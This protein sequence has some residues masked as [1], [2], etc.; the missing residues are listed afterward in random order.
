MNLMQLKN[1]KAAIL[2]GGAMLMVIAAASWKI[3]GASVQE[4]EAVGPP[5]CQFPT[6]AADHLHVRA[7]LDNAVRYIA[8]ESRTTD[9][10][11]G[12]P[13]EGWNDEPEKQLSLRSFTQLTAIGEWIEILANVIAGHVETPDLDREQAL[14]HLNLAIGTLRCDQ[15]DPALAA[16]GLLVNFMDLASGKRL[17]PLAHD[18][19]KSAFQSGFDA[20]KGEAIWQALQSKGWLVPRGNGKEADIRRS[21]EYGSECFDGPLM[22]FADDATKQKIM[23]ILDRRVVTVVFGDNA[24]LSISMAR[25]IGAI[26]HP[27]FKDDL[28]LEKIRKEMECFLDD[29]QEGYAH[30]YDVQARKFSFGWDA[31]RNRFLGWQDD[32]GNFCKGYMDYLV[33]E[34]RGPT[35]F[36]VLRFGLPVD[37]LKNLG[38]KIKP[39]RGRGA[40]DAYVLAPWDGSAFQSFG[41]G[42]CM[43]EL[44][45][46][47]WKRL[48]ENVVDVQIDYAAR[49]QLPGFL[50]ESYTG[51]GAQY[52]GEVGIPDIAVTT[53]PRI[54]HAASLYT[55]GI[56]YMI[57]P[58]KIER[59]LARNWPAI[60]RLLTDHG[61]WEG[62]NLAKQEAISVQTS[63]HTFSLILGLLGTGPENMRRYLESINLH[64]PLAEI[65][66][67]G[68]DFD[69][70]KND[71]Q[72]FAW[73]D[74]Q[75]EV[76]S[77]RDQQGFHVKSDRLD[78]MGIAFV[79]SQPSGVNLS[80]GIL[81]IAYRSSEPID[82]VAICFKPATNGS[83]PTATIPNELFTRFVPTNGQQAE[84]HAPLPATPALA[85]IK[86][87]VI[88]ADQPGGVNLTI[89]RLAFKPFAE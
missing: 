38:F 87:V 25:A 27:K 89:T 57:A 19:E 10:L 85:G 9:P 14:S 39:Y 86:E 33:N 35:S 37:A 79:P 83:I 15:K 63:A 50:S 13:V 52:T 74:K 46:P 78:Q 7:L 4:S 23:Q 55:L 40:D 28:R 61:P 54:T 75:A 64:V 44:E 80:G 70:L 68:G 45:D 42:L 49:Y 62:Y 6:V 53:A 51:H 43:G 71:T 56:A 5:R 1:V 20:E 24:N 41:L 60:S 48:L 12:Y 31:T 72:V 18:I 11:S 8:P 88:T 73:G 76:K 26:L 34:F 32:K 67:P 22:P 66:K 30:L 21:A 82:R 58:E 81:S 29:Q 77:T 69:F 84:I 2:F 3:K 65:A 17:A 36:V 47:S 59:F 16:R